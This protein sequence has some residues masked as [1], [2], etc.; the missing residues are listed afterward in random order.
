MGRQ[1]LL[2]LQQWRQTLFGQLA[3]RWALWTILA[4]LTGLAASFW[5]LREASFK[6]DTERVQAESIYLE[7]MLSGSVNRFMAQLRQVSREPSVQATLLD[8]RGREQH[9][10]QFMRLNMPADGDATAEK[11]ANLRMAVL[12]DRGRTLAGSGA[13]ESPAGVQQAVQD[14]L[15]SEQPQARFDAQSTQLVLA[16]PLRFPGTGH[17]EG[18]VLG[19]FDLGPALDSLIAR[20]G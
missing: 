8:S 6:R 3:I 4:A 14:V 13:I 7:S 1:M 19:S 2:Q 20:S 5:V 12:D 9:M 16:F 17:T 11:A 10:A 15:S 18:V